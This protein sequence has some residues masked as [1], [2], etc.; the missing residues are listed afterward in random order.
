MVISITF[1]LERKYLK[2]DRI[3]INYR[4]MGPQIIMTPCQICNKPLPAAMKTCNW[5]EVEWLGHDDKIYTFFIIGLCE[6]NPPLTDGF[7]PQRPVMRIFSVSLMSAWRNC[8]TNDQ[9]T[10]VLRRIDAHTTSLP[11]WFGR[12]VAALNPIML[13]GWTSRR[14]P[15]QNFQW[16]IPQYICSLFY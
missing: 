1:F 8:W 4:P 9:I 14:V 10:S 12:L 11:R 2:L 6:R 3:S 5:M 7:H 16:N 15:Y 13:S